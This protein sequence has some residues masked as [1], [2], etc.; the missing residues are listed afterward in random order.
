MKIA[1]TGRIRSG[2]DTVSDYIQE[3]Y[4]FCRFSFGD[5]IRAV[6]RRVFPHLLLQ[7]KPRALYQ[8]VGQALREFDQDVWVK[9]L[10]RCIAEECWP[11]DNILVTDLRQPN[12]Y[13][14]LREKGFLI[15]RVSSS[16]KTRVQRAYRQGDAFSIQD[17]NHETE[18]YVDDFEV[19][20]T[21]SNDRTLA[22]LYHEVDV[23]LEYL[24][25]GL[26]E[27]GRRPCN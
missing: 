19:D 21:I 23:M 25:G 14:Y 26:I 13:K 9:Y 16:F 18:A 27:P 4:E 22:D 6:C 20:Y 11:E 3:S 8:S 7:G 5:G 12:E 2:K 1:L 17:F 10:D 24:G 15:V